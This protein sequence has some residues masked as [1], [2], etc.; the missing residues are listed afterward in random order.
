MQLKFIIP[1]IDTQD[2]VRQQF[3]EVMQCFKDI[4][5]TV[6][7]DGFAMTWASENTRVAVAK[8]EAGKCLGVAVMCFGRRWY[9]A[10]STASVIMLEGA[11][12]RELMQF[13]RDSCKIL[14]VSYIYLQKEPGDEYSG[15]EV[16]MLKMKV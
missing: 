10:E 3:E 2:G 15:E 6:D 16:V 5:L 12:R 14:G 8:D 9:D 11:V 1:N 13:L 7:T 4:N